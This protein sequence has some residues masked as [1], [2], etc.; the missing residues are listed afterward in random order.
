MNLKSYS[1]VVLLACFLAACAGKGDEYKEGEVLPSAEEL[2]NQ[3]FD[4]FEN[5]KKKDA[6]TKFE[7]IER[8]YPYSK[9]ATKA[10]V[11][12]AYVSYEDQEYDKAIMALER[13]IQLHPGNK[14]VSYAYYLKALCYYEQIS[15]VGRDQ[16]YTEK[17]QSSLKEVVSRFPKTDYARDARLKLDL[18]LDHLAGKEVEVGR[19]YQH[20]RKNPAAIN[21]FQ[22]VIEQYQTTSH[23]P[24]ALHRLVEVYYSLGVVGEAQKYA[25][26]LG[27]NFPASSWYGRSYRLLTGQAYSEG[28]E[29]PGWFER[30]KLSIPFTKKKEVTEVPSIDTRSVAESVE[31]EE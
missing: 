23:V 9:W 21:R 29:R 6:V 2:Y 18:V 10:Q 5:N 31:A 3:A 27:H 13:F 4:A 22:R 19:F 14:Y 11:M 26:V 20:R 25:A 16:S 30:F 15:D 17:A 24:E 12:A 1:V 7:D 28:V 8:T